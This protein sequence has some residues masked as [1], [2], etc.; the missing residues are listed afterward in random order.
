MS[1][2]I[3]LTVLSLAQ[4]GLIWRG[5][6]LV[7]GSW[8]DDVQTCTVTTVNSQYLQATFF[9]SA[10]MLVHT[11]VNDDTDHRPRVYSDGF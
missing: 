2:V 6:F 10:F 4:W 8:S 7:N 9:Y 5:M 3:P 11:A 1:I